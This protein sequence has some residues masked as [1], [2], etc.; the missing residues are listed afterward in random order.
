VSVA[1]EIYVPP[2][3]KET[4]DH[5]NLPF[6]T[7]VD[8][9]MRGCISPQR[10]HP[11]YPGQSP[12]ILT[13]IS[14]DLTNHP[15]HH[16]FVFALNRLGYKQLTTSRLDPAED[17]EMEFWLRRMKAIHA[18]LESLGS[19]Q[20]VLIV[21]CLDVLFH[22]DPNA[23]LERFKTLTSAPTAEKKY[24][25]DI[26][27]AAEMLCDTASCRKTSELKD[28]MISQA[29]YTSKSHKFPRFLNAGTA[30][31]RAGPFAELIAKVID[32]MEQNEIDDQAIIPYLKPNF[33]CPP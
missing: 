15:L 9:G 16:N 31:G 17:G 1:K 30:I 6:Y 27:Y 18:H 8:V 14:T 10:S 28:F 12:H 5:P 33:F 24:K 32:R 2:I 20:I 13:T 11:E 26:V 19:S 29:P 25:Y 7:K 22:A 4:N 21:D 23:I 3:Q